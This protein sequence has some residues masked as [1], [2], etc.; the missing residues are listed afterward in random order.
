MAQEEN[1]AGLS[2]TPSI[3]QSLHPRQRQEWENGVRGLRVTQYA[4]LDE[5]AVAAVS[6]LS[7]LPIVI[8]LSSLS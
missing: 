8:V 4:A 6:G 2:S 7:G 3:R 5:A 1:L